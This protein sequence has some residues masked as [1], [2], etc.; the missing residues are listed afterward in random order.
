MEPPADEHDAAL[1]DFMALI[2]GATAGSA[3]VES[4]DHAVVGN[5]S[6][7][8][9]IAAS[10]AR[11]EIS[12]PSASADV[13]VDS[14]D[15]YMASLNNPTT[16]T[17]L[18]DASGRRRGRK[19]KQPESAGLGRLD[20]ELDDELDAVDSFLSAQQKELKEL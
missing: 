16:G 8:E 18:A 9:E 20:V 1:L 14:L 19:R 13:P 10:P 17:G 7:P 3:A 11:P 4:F 5:A 2:E 6:I 12:A 15:A